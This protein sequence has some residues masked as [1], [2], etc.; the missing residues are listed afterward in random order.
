LASSCLTQ[1][2]AKHRTLKVGA[3]QELLEASRQRFA[4]PLH[5]ERYHHRGEVVESVFGFLRSVL[6]FGRWMLRGR[7]RV[8]SEAVLWK[9]AYQF[10]KVQTARQAQTK[11]LRAA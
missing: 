11:A 1:A 2:R 6:G 7:E 8:A 10:R 5:Q 4:D 3:Y 9:L